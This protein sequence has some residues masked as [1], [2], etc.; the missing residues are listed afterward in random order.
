VR[1]IVLGIALAVTLF[2]SCGPGAM[3]TQPPQEAAMPVDDSEL[4]SAL[5]VL[6]SASGA[7]PV[8][9]TAITSENIGSFAPAPE[10]AAAVAR[11]FASHGFRVDPLVG[12]SFSI[13]APAE[14]FSELFGVPL[15]RRSDGAIVAV[16]SG[17]ET[18][19][20]PLTTIP[21]EIRRFVSAVTFTPPPAFGPTNF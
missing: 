14:R 11:F 8:A 18:L 2:G 5:V 6:R 10:A 12:V 16:Q 21:D 15:E 19:E 3:R 7:D 9:A 1:A 20:L 4:I 13:T 17:T